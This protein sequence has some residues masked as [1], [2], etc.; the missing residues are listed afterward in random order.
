MIRSLVL[1]CLVPLLVIAALSVGCGGESEST[2]TPGQVAL[3]AVPN[4][5]NASGQQLFTVDADGTGLA[6]LTYTD[7]DVYPSWS[8][9]G[10]QIL[11]SRVRGAVVDDEIWIVGAAGENEHRLTFGSG[12]DWSPDGEQVAFTRHVSDELD[13]VVVINGD[14]SDERS[15]VSNAS[16]AAWSPDGDHI[17]F[18]RGDAFGGSVGVVDADGSGVQLLTSGSDDGCPSWSPDGEEIAYSGGPKRQLYVMKADGSGA[19]LV[20][21]TNNSEDTFVSACAS[22]SPDGKQLLF[23]T[24]DKAQDSELIAVVKTDGTNQR[25]L[26]PLPSE[27]DWVA[28]EQPVWSP[29]GRQILYLD[30]ND[31]LDGQLWIM[32]ADGSARHRFTTGPFTQPFGGPDWDQKRD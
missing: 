16:F 20:G 5:A 23:T 31:G 14:G 9:D 10:K 7:G 15:L 28:H 11:F 3:S 19:H 25:I 4:E 8:P 17:L 22:W 30:A 21:A 26:S 1:K 2:P 29:D 13:E 6:R 27:D 32:N 24:F 18:E 12:A